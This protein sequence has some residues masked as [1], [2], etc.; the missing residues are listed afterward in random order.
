MM[1]SQKL[2]H[3]GDEIQLETKGGTFRGRVHLKNADRI[4]LGKIVDLNTG[5]SLP[6]LRCFLKKEVISSKFV[7]GSELASSVS[8]QDDPTT[9]P[10]LEAIRVFADQ[11]ETVSEEPCD[12]Q[13]VDK[14]EEEEEEEEYGSSLDDSV[15][16]RMMSKIS[17]LKKLL[18]DCKISRKA[19]HSRSQEQV[20]NVQEQI[21]KSPTVDKAHF[22]YNYV[23]ID[24]IGS[25]FYNSI[26]E[27]KHSGSI[28]VA[29]VGSDI[30]RGTDFSWV[31]VHAKDF[32]LYDILSLGDL[33][34]A[35]GLKDV[36]HDE[37]IV[38]IVFDC[39]AASH[40]LLHKH[41]SLLTNVIDLMAFE[42]MANSFSFPSGGVSIK[43]NS[44]VTCV[45]GN[46]NP[47]VVEVHSQTSRLEKAR[48]DN[49]Y[50]NLRIRGTADPLREEFED[51]LQAVI[52]EVAHLRK[53]KQALTKKMMSP[54]IDATDF[55]LS[56]F[57]DTTKLQLLPKDI[58]STPKEF[59]D[60][61]VLGHAAENCRNKTM[62]LMKSIDCNLSNG[63][64]TTESID[65]LLDASHCVSKKVTNDEV[66]SLEDE[67][68]DST[69]TLDSKSTSRSLSDQSSN[70]R[71][72]S[73][74]MAETKDGRANAD[75]SFAPCGAE[76]GYESNTKS[77]KTRR[78]NKI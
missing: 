72:L 8:D 65:R 39:R 73:M 31:A 51:M 6:G 32:Y 30:E 69:E 36:F 76:I 27:L 66:V 20:N 2:L 16:I 45:A 29:F 75:I 14:N 63:S 7:R 55:L 56:S 54:V 28:G 52:F 61:S 41:K 21:S 70:N 5:V 49:K 9:A 57:R 22:R 64:N 15:D 17:K 4:Y 13:T 34:F 62:K 38:K 19:V 53:L 40:T 11:A 35:E 50:W 68:F 42:V 71:L 23:V 24:S 37:N 10:K 12:V 44:L 33:A 26:A 67:V 47:S 48:N 78:H 59:K 74:L 46:L 18:E 43:M 3:A 25:I 77:K 60:R 1:A 58:A